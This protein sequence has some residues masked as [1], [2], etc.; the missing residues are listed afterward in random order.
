MSRPI[1]KSLSGFTFY[2]CSLLF[3]SSQTALAS[4]Q[5]IESFS[6]A[7]V[8]LNTKVYKEHRKTLYCE[9][10]FDV[11][12]NITPPIGFKA[13][14]Y[15]NRVN[16][17]EWEHV[18]PAE[19]FGRTFKVWRQGDALCVTK[20]G[21]LFKGRRCAE[22][23]NREYRYMQA[24]LFNLYPAIGSV[25]ALR[26]NYNFT[27]LP[28]T[29]SNFGTCK[30]KIDNRKAEPPEQA[31]GRI[32]RTYLYMEAAYPRYSMSSQQKKLMA[33]W[34]KMYPVTKWECERTKKITAIQKNDNIVVKKQC[35]EKDFW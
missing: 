29:A 28:Q 30:M 22:K 15:L 35:M 31:R 13:S 14:K 5:L 11:N 20:K 9:A 2:F 26:S 19:N 21:K 1:I 34:N 12:K 33:A 25:N 4:N 16:R 8:L 24:D 23:M 18:I 7:K 17:V 10:H 27:M 3:L 6:Q 32:A